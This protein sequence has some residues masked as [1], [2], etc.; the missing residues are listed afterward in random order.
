MKEI[1]AEKSC[2]SPEIEELHVIDPKRPAPAWEEIAREDPRPIRK[3]RD[4]AALGLEIT[5]GVSIA[6]NVVFAVIIYL[7]IPAVR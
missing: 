3:K 7:M 6:L 4:R 5:A 2:E 1:T